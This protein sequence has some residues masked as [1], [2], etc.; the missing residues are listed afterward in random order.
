MQLAVLDIHAQ[1]EARAALRL[2]VER[3]IIALLEVEA[4]LHARLIQGQEG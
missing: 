2:H 3:I 1:L 4:Q